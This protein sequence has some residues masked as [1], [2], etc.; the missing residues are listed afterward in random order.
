MPQLY[1]DDIEN[2]IRSRFIKKLD[3]LIATGRADSYVDICD[4]LK[5][6]KSALTQIKLG[7]TKPTLRMLYNLQVVYG[8]MVEDIL[9]E[10]PPKPDVGNLTHQI[11]KLQDGLDDILKSINK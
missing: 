8:I 7:K 10:T 1:N 3:E 11:K 2:Q 4:N 5:I 6:F 9:F